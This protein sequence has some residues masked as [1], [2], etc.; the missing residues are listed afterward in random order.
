MATN[1]STVMT[2]HERIRSII[3]VVESHFSWTLDCPMKFGIYVPDIA[4]REHVPLL[5]FLSGGLD[6]PVNSSLRITLQIDLNCTEQNWITKSGMQRLA[7]K[8]G[9]LVANPDTSPRKPPTRIRW[10]PCIKEKI[11][12]QVVLKS[13]WMRTLGRVQ[14]TT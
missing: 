4:D 11:I 2:G 14:D 13:K 5:I 6:F 10:L 9:F 7:S 8:Y 12:F 1:M 3:A